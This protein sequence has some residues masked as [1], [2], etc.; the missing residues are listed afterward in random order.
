[1]RINI[2]EKELLQL[3]QKENHKYIIKNIYQND[4]KKILNYVKWVYIPIKKVK[5]LIKR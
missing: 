3:S 1:M 4:S 5:K 2:T